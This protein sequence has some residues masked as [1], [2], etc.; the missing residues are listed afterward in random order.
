MFSWLWKSRE[1]VTLTTGQLRVLTERLEALERGFK[2][3]RDEWE[4]HYERSHRLLGRLNARLRA[5]KTDDHEE[6]RAE[7]EA[8]PRARPNI[9]DLRARYLRGRTA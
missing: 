1:D 7:P 9:H 4:E 6:E 8:P 2:G 5:S 3:I